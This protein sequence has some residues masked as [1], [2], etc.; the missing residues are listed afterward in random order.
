[1]VLLFSVI[2]LDVQLGH[3][4]RQILPHLLAHLSAIIAA[5]TLVPRAVVDAIKLFLVV[6]NAPV[7]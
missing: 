7:K 5:G 3:L 1:L 4:V 6:N 2:D